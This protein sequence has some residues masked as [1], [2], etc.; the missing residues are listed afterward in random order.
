MIFVK[1]IIESLKFKIFFIMNIERSLRLIFRNKTY[2]IL[3]I[4]GLAIGIAASALILLWVEYQMNDNRSVPNRGNLYRMGQNQ[5]YGDDVRT[6][7]VCSSGLFDALNDN[8]AGVKRSARYASYSVTFRD[9]EDNSSFSESGAYTDSS[10]FAMIDLPFVAG[11]P[12]T[13]FEPAY[14]V[15]I[16]QKMAK[17]ISGDDHPLGKTLYLNN[18]VY[19][20]T[21]V[22]KDREENGAFRFEWLIPCRILE[23]DYIEKGWISKGSWGNWLH[24]YVEME[25]GADVSTVDQYLTS[26]LR[27][28]SGWDQRNEIFLYPIQR[29]RL[30]GEFKDG[31]ETGSGY[32]RTVRMFFAIGMAIMLIACINFMNMNTARSQKR[33]M[34]IGV[35][36]VFGAKFRRL[37]GQFMGESA[38]VTFISLAVAVVLVLMALP[39]FNQLISL[40]LAV[41]IANPYH[42]IGLLGVGLLCTLLSGVYPA[43]YMSSFSPIHTLKK[44]KTNVAGSAALVR[45]GLVVFQFAVSFVLICSTAIIYLQIRHVQNRPLGLETKRLVLFQTPDEMQRNFASVQEALIHTGVVTHSGLSNQQIIFLGNNGGG[46]KWQGKAPDVDPLVSQLSVSP[47]LIEAAGIRFSEG[48][49]FSW[50]LFGE[51]PEVII[52][53]SFADMMGEEGRTGGIIE[54]DNNQYRIIG[55]VEDFVFNDYARGKAEPVIFNP[56]LPGSRLFVRLKEGVRE[57][58]A[59]ATVQNTLKQFS[60][61]ASFEPSYMDEIFDRGFSEQRFTGK[62]AG[63]FSALAVFLSCMGLFG[64]SAYSAEQRTKEIGIRKVL[65]ASVWDIVYLLGRSFMQLLLIA[66]VIGIP[67]AWYAGRIYLQ[68]YE[69]RMSLQWYIFAGAALLVFLIAMLTVSAQSLRAATA[70]PLKAIKSE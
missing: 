53:R 44:L 61:A 29:L 47:G 25:P 43:F 39:P 21:G 1:T 20:V 31:K 16:S 69:Y 37:V 8:L 67:A 36:K 59:I 7:F 28:R 35:R 50:Q 10:L 17:K 11:N 66:L 55:I 52:N 23:N 40:H 62:L 64:L 57:S 38:I 60:P 18:Q 42:S 63:L 51:K 12:Q 24:C 54:R 14:P 30:Y 34:E 70:N 46:Y 13:A 22:F 32:I 4:S 6:F 65:G 68:G 3:N 19:E 9:D 33:A 41:D 45:K 27:D 58:E 56:Y 48:E 15:V 2:S 49:D 5:F 26:V